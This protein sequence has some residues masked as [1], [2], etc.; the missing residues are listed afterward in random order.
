[1]IDQSQKWNL[2]TQNEAVTLEAPGLPGFAF[3]LS[4]DDELKAAAARHYIKHHRE[5]LNA[6]EAA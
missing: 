4:E 6:L 2:A 5:R 3:N 1:M